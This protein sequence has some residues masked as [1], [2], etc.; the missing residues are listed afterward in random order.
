M[1]SLPAKASVIGA[2]L[3]LVLGIEL[4]ELPV[5]VE[6]GD[7]ELLAVGLYGRSG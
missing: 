4:D 3:A 1:G 6:A 7:S 5:G 2:A